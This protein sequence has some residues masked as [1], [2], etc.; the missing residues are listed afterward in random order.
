MGEISSAVSTPPFHLPQLLNTEYSKYCEYSLFPT[1]VF[2]ENSD[3]SDSLGYFRT[4]C[5]GYADNSMLSPI[6]FLFEQITDSR[7]E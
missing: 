4:L 6:G 5:L 3:N 7:M 1:Q 2:M